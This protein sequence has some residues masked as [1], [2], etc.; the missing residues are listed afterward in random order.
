MLADLDAGETKAVAGARRVANM[1]IFILLTEAG[2]AC[3]WTHEVSM[4]RYG[5]CTV[6]YHAVLVVS[7]GDYGL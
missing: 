2:P 1:L 6:P 4:V 3:G 7:G 5:T